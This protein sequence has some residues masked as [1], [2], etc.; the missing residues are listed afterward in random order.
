MGNLAYKENLVYKE[1]L[2]YKENPLFPYTLNLTS[3]WSSS[4]GYC[5]DTS[6]VILSEWR[7]TGDG[8]SENLNKRPK[9]IYL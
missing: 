9:N 7:D 2:A 4:K 3:W 6:E 5:I 8:L 1:N